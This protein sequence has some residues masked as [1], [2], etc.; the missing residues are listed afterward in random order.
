MT[1]LAARSAGL[2][3]KYEYTNLNWGQF[4]RELGTGLTD[5]DGRSIFA[6]RKD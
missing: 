1:P 4:A 6:A 2:T 3:G 5:T